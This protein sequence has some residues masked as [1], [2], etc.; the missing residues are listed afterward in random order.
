MILR[1]AAKALVRYKGKVLILKEADYE[2]GSNKGLFGLPGGRLDLGEK[3]EDGLR[4]EVKEETGLTI[5]NIVRPLHVGEWS[6]EIKGEINQIV[7]IFM[8]V[9]V[10]TDKVVLSEEHSE[11]AWIK[12]EAYSGYN[13]MAADGEVFQ[14]Y[15]DS[16]ST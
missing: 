10:D 14:A 16:R 11:H 15:I 13:L 1:V 9:D 12:P 2:E 7:A 5:K 3:F 8:L 6:P 4:R